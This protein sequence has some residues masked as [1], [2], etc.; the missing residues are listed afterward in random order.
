MRLDTHDFYPLPQTTPNQDVPVAQNLNLN[1]G[2]REP[3]R[4]IDGRQYHAEWPDVDYSVPN[5]A[6]ANSFL[7]LMH[8]AIKTLNEQELP[9]FASTSVL[10]SSTK[11]R[12]LDI[13]CGT[14]KRSKLPV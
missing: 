11:M 9:N 14:G 12:A 13:G 1:A 6:D 3:Y 7:D 4:I 10:H 5:D 8:R 2:Q